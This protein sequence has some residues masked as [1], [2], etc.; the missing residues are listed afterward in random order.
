LLDQEFT[1]TADMSKLGSGHNG[2]LYLT[3]MDVDGGTARFPTDKAGAKHGTGCCDS[4][5]SMLLASIFTRPNVLNLTAFP[6][7]IISDSGMFDT[8][9]NK[10]D[11]WD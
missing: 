9:C 2:A 3:E 7:D 10:M 5:C 6:T 4:Q 1:F 11:I 8:C